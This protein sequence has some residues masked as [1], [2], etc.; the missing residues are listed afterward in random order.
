MPLQAKFISA[1]GVLG[2]QNVTI[3]WKCVSDLL[4]VLV[5]HKNSAYVLRLFRDRLDLDLLLENG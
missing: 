2:I 5:A 4:K 3:N 1:L